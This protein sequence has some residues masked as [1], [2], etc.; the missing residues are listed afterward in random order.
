MVSGHVTMPPAHILV[1]AIVLIAQS[2]LIIGLLRQRARLRSAEESLRR[3]EATLRAS[4][5][6]TRQLAG[7]LITA[8]ED[9]RAAI[10]RDLHDDICQRLV[11]VSMGLEDL[12]NASA[13][14][15]A[16]TRRQLASK[17]DQ[18]LQDIFDGL[19]RLSREL[20]PSALR[21]LGLAPALHAHCA[22][23]ARRHRVQVTFT[24]DRDT[25]GLPPDVALCAFR[26]VQEALRNAVERGM[27]KQ[28]VVSLVR[29]ADTLQL[30]VED[31]GHGFDLEQVPAEAAFGLAMMRERAHAIGGHV[32]IRSEPGRGTRVHAHL[33][34]TASGSEAMAPPPPAATV[35]RTHSVT[36]VL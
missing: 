23:V 20:H 34:L 9:A 4:Y 25:D 35:P 22:E 32:E 18:D 24:P 1:I 3:S 10:A 6:R 13:S 7:R 15:D 5:A 19:R 31:D 28:C 2:L 12:A 30:T 27:P 8:Q 17:L 16:G 14:A 36:A 29:R 26:I 21:L 33:P 11:F